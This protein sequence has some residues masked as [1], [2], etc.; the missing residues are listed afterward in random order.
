MLFGATQR[1]LIL[2]ADG[3][4]VG[5]GPEAM[6]LFGS[7]LPD[8]ICP[9]PETAPERLCNDE[10]ISSWLRIFLSG[11]TGVVVRAA[12]S[13][14]LDGNA[15]PKEPMPKDSADKDG[16]IAGAAGFDTRDAL[17]AGLVILAQTFCPYGSRW[18][19]DI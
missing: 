6:T 10:A 7:F 19:V 3:E 17:W 4:L 8:L 18:I 16:I 5:T 13:G 1:R 12:D 9:K 11:L 14:I 15:G 2:G